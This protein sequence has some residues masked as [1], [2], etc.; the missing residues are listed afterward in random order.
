MTTA[1]LDRIRRELEEVRRN[2]GGLLRPA[3]VVAYASDPA[4]ALHSRFTWDDS[5]A[6][7]EYRLWQAREVIRVCVAVV[8]DDH[9]PVRAYVSLQDDRQE[10]G[11]GYRTLHSVLRNA[12]LRESLLEEAKADME[13]FETKYSLLSELA[14]VFTAMRKARHV[15]PGPVRVAT[16]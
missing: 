13:R 5:K 14:D 1:T 9:P 15:R 8:H 12:T 7:H 10:P 16:K 2:A 6:A 4:R 11:G 3:D